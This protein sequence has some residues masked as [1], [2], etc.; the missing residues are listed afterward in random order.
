MEGTRRRSGFL[1]YTIHGTDEFANI[2]HTNQPF[3]WLNIP[4]VDPMA[5]VSNMSTPWLLQ[6]IHH[7]LKSITYGMGRYGFWNDPEF[8]TKNWTPFP[9]SGFWKT[10]PAVSGAFVH[11]V[12]LQ[13]LLHAPWKPQGH[14]VF[15]TMLH[16]HWA[17]L[18]LAYSNSIRSSE[19]SG[20]LCVTY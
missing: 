4:C 20:I 9:G 12:W 11:Q 16:C 10:H 8:Q 18:R 7:T 1:S 13:D 5:F 17:H 3:M 6:N 2:Y 14:G 19:F 15:P